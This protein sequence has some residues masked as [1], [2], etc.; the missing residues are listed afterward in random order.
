MTMDMNRPERGQATGYNLLIGIATAIML[1]AAA[2]VA[3]GLGGPSGAYTAAAAETTTPSYGGLYAIV[4][5]SVLVLAL[6]VAVAVWR[7]VDGARTGGL[8]A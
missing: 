1:G 7:V 2:L 5:V 4:G 6:I 3:Y 8:D